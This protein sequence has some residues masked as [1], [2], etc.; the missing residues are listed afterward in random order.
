MKIQ[1]RLIPSVLG[2]LLFLFT[3]VTHGQCISGQAICLGWDQKVVSA[4]DEWRSILM[5][6]YSSD[7]M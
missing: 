2:S 1:I 7:R 3:A 6:T 4:K 5:F